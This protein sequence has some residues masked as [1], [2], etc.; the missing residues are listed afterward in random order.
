MKN[1][2]LHSMA[3]LVLTAS[4][5]GVM[6]Q[7]P[8]ARAP[9]AGAS[10]PPLVRPAPR[11]LTPAELRNS[12]TSPDDQPPEGPVVPQINIPF[13]KTPPPPKSAPHAARAGMTASANGANAGI[14]DAAARCE[15]Q[16]DASARAACRVK[17]TSDSRKH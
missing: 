16:E 11:P 5:S 7:T 10:A 4:A 6:A 9:S 15:A 1:H 8:A 2:C 14:G 12:A 17:L 3:I 13:G